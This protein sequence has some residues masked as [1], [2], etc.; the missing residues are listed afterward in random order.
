MAATNVTTIAITIHGG[1]HGS[2]WDGGIVVW[3]LMA[4]TIY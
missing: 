4:G 3:H 1:L 2:A